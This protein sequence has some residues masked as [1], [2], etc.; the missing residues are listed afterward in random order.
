LRPDDPEP[1]Y[2]LGHVGFALR[3]DD[4]EWIARRGLDR[5]LAIDPDYRDAWGLWLQLFRDDDD[6]RRAVAALARHAGERACDLRRALMLAELRGYAEARTILWSLVRERPDDVASRALLAQVLFEDG[7]DT[8]GAAAYEAALALADVDTAEVLWHQVRGIA[9]PGERVAW[10]STPPDA[11]AASLRLFW[12]RRRPDVRAED[13]GRLGEHFRRMAEARRS[14]GLQHPNSLW[15]HS[16]RYRSVVAGS[17]AQSPEGRAARRGLAA[18]TRDWCEP[19]VTP[20]DG[21]WM[22]PA[23]DD[24]ARANE[25]ANLEDR[26]DDRG[27]IFLRHGRPDA[28]F[29]LSGR[30]G[31]PPPGEVWCYRRGAEVF[32]VSFVRRSSGYL[33]GGEALATPVR[34]GEYA[35]TAALLAT[36]EPSPRAPLLSFS[37]WTAAFRGADARR[38]EVVLFLDSLDGAAELVNGA[39]QRAA[40]DLRERAPLRLTAAPGRYALLIDGARGSS[41]GRYRGSITLPDHG[42]NA[43]SISGILVADGDVPPVRDTM[44]ARAPARLVLRAGAP[45]RVYAEVYGLGRRDGVARYEARYRVE[46]TDGGLL[47]VS[48][49]QARGTTIAFRRDR[50][51]EPRAIE[52]VVID[53]GRLPRGRYRLVLEIADEVRERSASSASREFELR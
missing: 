15:H 24:P 7:R 3:G 30:G 23:P 5:V 34:P 42:G 32:R 27:R 14:F 8:E 13:N 39:G 20:P 35:S 52:T 43:L 17:S 1:L 26:L 31:E 41:I 44:I 45:I 51:F 38:T 10:G 19:N 40:R 11:R 25:S 12:A 48:G 28:T 46:R 50:P 29:I 2:W 53:P 36:D 37:F 4:G 9:S 6:R 18:E 47:R 22:A 33:L 16:A 21:Y 49:Q